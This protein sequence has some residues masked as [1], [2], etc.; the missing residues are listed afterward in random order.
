MV[1]SFGQAA[2]I[3]GLALGVVLLVM[4]EIVR[5][6]GGR[7]TIQ[8]VGLLTTV[9]VLTTVVGLAG[10]SAWVW[11]GSPSAPLERSASTVSATNNSIAVGGSVTG[12]TILNG[13]PAEKVP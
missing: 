12:G 6:A 2:G 11:A 8:T 10:I 1:K 5:K 3:G 9:A 4:R 13:T 7:G